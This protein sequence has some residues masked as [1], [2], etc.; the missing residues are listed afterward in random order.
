MTEFLSEASVEAL[1]CRFHELYESWAP[2]FGWETQQASRSAWEDV[3]ANN[4][5][6]MCAVVREVITQFLRQEP[7]K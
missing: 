7:D 6:L 3:P 2:S 1:A 5:A 4:R